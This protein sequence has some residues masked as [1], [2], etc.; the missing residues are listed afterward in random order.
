MV[1]PGRSQ[2]K[3]KLHRNWVQLDFP[4]SVC[5]VFWVGVNL[6]SEHAKC[7]DHHRGT[8]ITGL[9]GGYFMTLR[10]ASSF[11]SAIQSLS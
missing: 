4:S 8:R 3:V 1:R 9:F 6:T 11:K 7:P 5:W 2:K 10:L